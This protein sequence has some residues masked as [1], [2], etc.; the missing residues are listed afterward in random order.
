MPVPR[1][2]T[3]AVAPH[4]PAAVL[5]VLCWKWGSKYAP[6]HVNALRRQ[7]ARFYARPHRFVCCTNDARGLDAD[8]TVVPDPE[9]F[10]ALRSP[11]GAAFPA[12]YRR[13]RI[14]APDA[15]ALFGERFVCLDIDMVLVA[16][17]APLWDRAEPFVAYRDPLHPTQICGSMM[18]LTAGALPVVWDGFNPT[19][20]PSL[21]RAAGFRGSDQAWISFCARGA[22]TWGPE[23]GVYS[24]RKDVAGKGLPAGALVIV[25]HGSPKPWEV[26]PA[27]AV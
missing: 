9:D 25:Y 20:S 22:P 12:C 10:A 11:H 23:D 18:L 2:G 17:V 26:N 24:Y 6:E 8:I 13:L 3:R 16:D 15:A 4:Q 14:F 5:T 27:T 21:A 7:V 19:R 1:P